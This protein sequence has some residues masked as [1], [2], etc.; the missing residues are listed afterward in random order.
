M[1]EYGVPEADFDS[2]A[3]EVRANFGARVDAD[4][5]PADAAGLAA[6]LRESVGR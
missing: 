2:I 3:A 4:P 6:I 1:L 5:V